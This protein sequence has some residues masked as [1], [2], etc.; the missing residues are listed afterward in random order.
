MKRE[1]TCCWGCPKRATC[2][3]PCP[4]V[5][6]LLAKDVHH[7]QGREILVGPLVIDQVF[8]G[9]PAHRL[10]EYV[11]EDVR[12][13]EVKK[14][15]GLTDRQLR[16]LTMTISGHRSQREIARSLGLCQSTV[17]EH[18]MAARRKARRSL[19][20]QLR[21]RRRGGTAEKDRK[22]KT[23]PRRGFSVLRSTTK[24]ESAGG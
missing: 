14:I 18:L 13:R 15:P 21:A 16:V 4:P 19:E 11:G 17:G 5:E 12:P 23:V 6:E 22:K 7:F 9:D 1:K 2:T 20:E 3:K 10:A 24:D 8:S